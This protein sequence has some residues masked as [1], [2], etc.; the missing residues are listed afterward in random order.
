MRDRG[1]HG[2]STGFS[3]TQRASIGVET[4]GTNR[5]RT[6]SAANS[7]KRASTT[8]NNMRKMRLNILLPFA[9]CDAAIVAIWRL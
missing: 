1:T 5:Q 6:I 2:R 3:V 9:R 4:G 8:F 7:S